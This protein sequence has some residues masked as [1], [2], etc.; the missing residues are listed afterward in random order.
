MVSH[1][2]AWP[3]AGEQCRP[4]VLFKKMSPPPKFARLLTLLCYCSLVFCFVFVFSQIRQ[5]RNDPE[6][7]ANEEDGVQALAVELNLKCPNRSYFFCPRKKPGWAA[8]VTGEEM[9]ASRP[10][11]LERALALHR[12]PAEHCPRLPGELPHKRQ[13][14]ASGSWLDLCGSSPASGSQGLLQ[15]GETGER[16]KAC[17]A[18]AAAVPAGALQLRERQSRWLILHSSGC[19]CLPVLGRLA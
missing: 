16:G 13:S 2:Q 7:S 4:L 17:A 10:H 6:G 8:P 9:I 11:W 14:E 19:L 15:P 5:L 3:L 12:Q 18:A 1:Q